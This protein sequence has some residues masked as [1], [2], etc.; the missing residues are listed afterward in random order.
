MEERKKAEIPPLVTNISRVTTIL[1]CCQI[2]TG[3]SFNDIPDLLQTPTLATLIEI[4]NK[5]PEYPAVSLAGV[6]FVSSLVASKLIDTINH[7]NGNKRDN[8]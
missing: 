3:G 1:A 2:I 6:A 5:P 4:T 7:G 8:R